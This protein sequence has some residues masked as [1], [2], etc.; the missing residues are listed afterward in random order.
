MKNQI[1][2][3]KPGEDQCERCANVASVYM[4]GRKYCL[5]HSSMDKETFAAIKALR[6]GGLLK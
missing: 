4:N 2:P 5:A 1:R 6:Q 3:A